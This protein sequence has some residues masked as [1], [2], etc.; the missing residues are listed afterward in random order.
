[1]PDA[2]EADLNAMITELTA[3]LASADPA[4]RATLEAQ[5]DS[6]RRALAMGATA[7]PALSKAQRPN[8]SAEALEFFT[9]DPAIVVPCWLP[10]FVMRDHVNDA[11]VRCPAGA[12]VYTTDLTVGCAIPTGG[13]PVWHGL[14]ISF[15]RSK[16]L[17]SQRFYESGLLRWAIEYHPGGGRASVGFF[18]DKEPKVHR[19]QGLHTSYAPGGAVCGQVVWSAGIR[20][21]WTKLWE[22]DGYPVGATLYDQGRAIEHVL[23]DGTRKPSPR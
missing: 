3:E 17:Q 6:L 19:E 23:A 9:P 16:R 11:T 20:H 14:S 15:Y 22:D 10:D 18:V 21:G 7:R 8:L 1:M 2:R 13:I 5:I 12:R 4:M